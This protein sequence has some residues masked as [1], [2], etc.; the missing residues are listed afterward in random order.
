MNA[1]SNRR[2][3]LFR[4]SA[5]L[6]GL[7]V[8]H[9]LPLLAADTPATALSGTVPL[10]PPNKQPEGLKIPEAVSKKAGW[11]IVGLGELALEEV[12]PAFAMCKLSRPVALVSGHPDKA[13]KVAEAYGIKP[14]SIYDYDNFDTIAQNPEIDVVY[15][16]LPNSMHAE[17]TIRALKAGKN[18]LCEK[19]MATTL[20][21]ARR[22]IA[23]ADEARRQLMIAYRLHYEPLTQ[24]LIAMCQKQEHG[25]IKTISA[26][27]CQDVAPP[28]IRLS[29]KLGGGPLGDVGIYCINAARYVTGEQ[30]AEVTGVAY[31]PADDPRFREV[32]ESVAFTLRFP[33]GI[34][35]DCH[36]SFGSAE[37]RSLQINSAKGTI[38]MDNAF[39][40]RG[41]RL[42]VKTGSPETKD[43]EKSEQL[44]RAADHFTCEMD[45]FSDCVLN[46]KTCL[47]P[48]AMG[49][50]DMQVIAAIEE[51][52]KTGQTQKVG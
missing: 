45:H 14:A 42:S 21:D 22:M 26:C 28:N 37:N 13:K 27:N 11:A 52:A 9:G 50:A 24:A 19:P 1:P 12:M 47:T 40:Y 33:S 30:P 7:G 49:L 5:A 6:A 23:A 48:G 41:Q 3:F 10:A 29:K 32:P 17:F 51:A 31:Q 34:L 38:I 46:G 25:K 16:I 8:L 15:I 43:A 44:I 39:A 2:E 20:E 35:A 4:S 18:V 36:C